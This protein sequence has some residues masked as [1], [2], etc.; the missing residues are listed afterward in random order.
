MLAHGSQILPED[1]WKIVSY[2][3]QKIQGGQGAQTAVIAE[4]KVSTKETLGN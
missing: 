3:K 4:A 2:V 1:R